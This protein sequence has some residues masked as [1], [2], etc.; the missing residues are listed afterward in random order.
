MIVVDASVLASVLVYSD[1]RGRKARA[2]L[3]RDP[4]W[5]APEHWKV[6]VFSVMRG[7]ALGGKITNEM[8]ARAVDRISR[9]GVDTV[10]IDDLLTRMWQVKANISAYDAPYVALAERRALTLVT[11]DGKLARA[12]SAYCRVELVA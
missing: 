2:V 5:A 4:E 12:A 8:A 11:A 1:D 6:E 10:P 9:L 7:L 3:G